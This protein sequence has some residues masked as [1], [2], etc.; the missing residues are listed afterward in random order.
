MPERDPLPEHS[1]VDHKPGYWM[2]QTCERCRRQYEAQRRLLYSLL[3]ARMVD[4]LYP[5][6]EGKA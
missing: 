6:R 3:P 5:K 4:P 1:P 2:T